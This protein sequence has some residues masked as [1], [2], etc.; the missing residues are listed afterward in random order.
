MSPTTVLY[1]AQAIH[2]LAYGMLLF[3]IASGLTMI[4]G[5][6]GI[7]NIAHASFAMLSAYFCYQVLL[8]TENFW[9]ALLV[10][11]VIAGFC[12]VLTE[13]FL[14]RTV[15]KQGH[16]AELLITVGI[17]MVILEIVKIGWGTESLVVKIPPSL[18][19]LVKF[20]G[21]TY[22]VYR[23]FVIG[24]SI[25]ILGIMALLLFKTRL[26]KIVRAAVSDADMVSSLGINTPLVFM[27][28]FGIGIW[29]AGVAGAVAGPLLTVFPGMADQ[30]GMDAFVVVV[31]GGFGS[32]SGA[33]IVALFLGELNAYGIQ[34]IPRLAPVLMFAFM[35]IVLAFKPM[36]L[37]GERE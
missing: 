31:V 26:G 35:A 19:G 23:I 33:F 30:L 28:V 13:R 20:A 11:P 24:L 3:L 17:M 14:L 16:L 7:L 21:L 29:L 15:H 22:P 9:V 10:A 36:G 12:G 2:G 37:F 32:L 25:V 34:F 5:M 18:S 27:L 4:F 8:M 1:V 6:M